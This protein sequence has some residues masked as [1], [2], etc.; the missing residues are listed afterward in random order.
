MYR[1]ANCRERLRAFVASYEPLVLVSLLWFLVQYLRLAFP[2]LFGTIQSEFGVSNTETGLLFTCLMM[3]Y[4]VMQFPTGAASDR[5]GRTRTISVAA[6]F[7][8]AVGLAVLFAYSF[9]ALLTLA[10]L[11]G[12]T[13][14]AHKTVSINIISNTYPEDTG[15]CLGF[16]DTIGQFGGVVAPIVAVSLLSL[17]GWRWTFALA[18]IVGLV[19]AWLNWFRISDQQSP[20]TT[21][22]DSVHTDGE[23]NKWTYLDVLSDGRLVIFIG[24]T[25]A[26]TFAWNGVSAFLPLYLTT[27][28][29]LSTQ[30]SSLLYSGFFAVSVSQIA[31]GRVSDSSSQLVIALA[32]FSSMIVSGFFLLTVGSIVAVGVLTLLLGVAFHGFRPVRDS[33]LM[34]LIPDTIGGGG[35]GIIRTGMVV[36]GAV[37]PSVVG[38]VADVAGYTSAFGVVLGV[39]LL[40][41]VLIAVLVVTKSASS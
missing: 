20:G 30:A 28:K 9:V 24:V 11:I 5:I 25:M 8:S 23:G 29:G 18:G 4:A 12:A 2:P 31:T 15:L 10:V 38:F 7:F 16:F 3:A 40:G 41:A 36:V 37:A 17:V 35:L 33:Y 1:F 26:F 39:L 27:E 21:S 22:T 32:L 6:V 14:A 13:T 19:L 34:T